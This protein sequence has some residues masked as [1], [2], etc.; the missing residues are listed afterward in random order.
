MDN[1][2]LDTILESD[3]ESDSDT[4]D[5]DDLGLLTELINDEVKDKWKKKI[6]KREFVDLNKLHYSKD[7]NE[8][9]MVVK[10]T[11]GNS[12]TSVSKKPNRKINNILSWSFQ[13]YAS[14]YCIKYPEES[15][16]M[17]Q[18][19]SLIHTMA[20]SPLTGSCMTLN[21]GN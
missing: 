18:Y 15:A 12:V 4:N 21:F 9:E 10:K 3:G 11:K 8:V 1:I 2:D 7:D 14:I 17:F 6:W 16:G 19:I 5:L 20:K 13:L